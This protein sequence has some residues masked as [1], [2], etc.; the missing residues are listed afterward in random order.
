MTIDG[1]RLVW[2]NGEVTDLIIT[3]PR[4]CTMAEFAG[5]LDAANGTLDWYVNGELVDKWTRLSV[6]DMSRGPEPSS[7]PVAALVADPG[8]DSPSAV[9]RF[10]ATYGVPRS[11]PEAG[12]VP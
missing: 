3:G 6:P 7:A 11:S 4:T 8:A 1:Q 5:T 9:K 12:G 2:P 10:R